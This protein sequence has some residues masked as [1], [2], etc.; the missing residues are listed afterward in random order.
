ML[1]VQIFLILTLAI[2]T[3]RAV[4]MLGSIKKYS[5][6]PIRAWHQGV[7][8]DRVS[9]IVPCR[10]EARNIP[11]LLPSLLQQDYPNVE[12]I[13]LDDRPTDNTYA[14]LEEYQQK[15]PR[16]RVLKGKPLPPGWTGKNYAMHQCA[17]E[18]TGRWLLFTDADTEHL[19]Y[20][21]SSSVQY[22]EDRKV[23]LLTLSARCVCKSFGE[24]L[25]QPMG[26]GCFSV[27]FKLEDVNDPNSSTPLCCGQ[28]ILIKKEVYETAG[29]SERVKDAVTEDLALFKNVKSAGYCCE[30]AI[31]AHIFATRMYQSLKEAWIGWRRIYL[32]AF[33]KN[34]PLLLQKIFMLIFCSFAPFLFLA[35]SGIQWARGF[36]EFQNVFILSA[37]LCGLIL[38][39]RSRSH[40]ALKAKQWAILLHPLS[41]LTVAAIIIDCLRH[42][43]LGKKVEWKAQHY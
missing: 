27:W 16:I 12:F 10:N 33:E 2:W 21:V 22:A 40:V 31:G 18:A 32:H 25:I 3:R 11:I 26:I 38:F 7:T 15:D 20:S 6:M 1:F 13:F 28:Y 17:K 4:L 24:H 14:L 30:L 29:G 37:I 39:L 35:V 19:N 42:H 43:F 8:P 36:T 34:I 23:D 41:A 5:I 9:V